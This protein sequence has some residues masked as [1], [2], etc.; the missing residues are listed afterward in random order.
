MKGFLSIFEHRSQ[1][2]QSINNVLSDEMALEKMVCNWLGFPLSV[3]S[4][5]K[6]S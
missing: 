6:S 1:I 4:M 3:M 2:E 5:K